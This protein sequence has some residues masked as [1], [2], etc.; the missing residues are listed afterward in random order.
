MHTHIS[1]SEA[2]VLPL[3]CGGARR[4]PPSTTSRAVGM[5]TLRVQA[6]VEPGAPYSVDYTEEREIEAVRARHR[7]PAPPL[8][9]PCL[10][11]DIRAMY[12]RVPLYPRARG[13]RRPARR[14]RRFTRGGARTAGLASRVLRVHAEA[15]IE[16]M[17]SGS[18]RSISAVSAINASASGW[19]EDSTSFIK[20]TFSVDTCTPNESTPVSCRSISRRARC[21]VHGKTWS[22]G[23]T[24]WVR[25]SI[26]STAK[27]MPI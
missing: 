7:D 13:A 21:I 22:H 17:L 9:P 26:L 3:R 4:A 25:M 15:R 19:S 23:I 20:S 18:N 10:A 12:M 11:P 24:G 8:P 1:C 16:L 2:R 6:A 5:D 27:T 14:R